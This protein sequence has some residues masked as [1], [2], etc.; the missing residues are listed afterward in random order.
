MCMWQIK[1][2]LIWF[3]LIWTKSHLYVVP[4][5][6][7]WPLHVFV[8]VCILLT[9]PRLTLPGAPTSP[10]A[11]V[12]VS[13]VCFYVCV[14][15]MCAFFW[16][17][18]VCVCLSSTFGLCV[19]VFR[20]CV[21][22]YKLSVGVCFPTPLPVCLCAAHLIVSSV[23]VKRPNGSTSQFIYSFVLHQTQPLL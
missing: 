20:V 2:D 22:V 14:S 13:C 11:F 10:G 7:A 18:R 19:F 6:E 17:Y 9:F 5:R 8:C 4:W 16:V 15:C 12:C 23:N 1:F 3:D 21:C